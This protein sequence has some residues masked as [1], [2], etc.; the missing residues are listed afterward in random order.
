MILDG[1]SPL[2]NHLWQS[3]LCVL[4]VWLLTLAMKRNRAAVRYWLWLAA[5]MKFLVPFS[6][7]VSAGSQFGWHADA[8]V[9]QPQLVHAMDEIARP[10]SVAAPPPFSPE[11]PPSTSPVVAILLGLWLCG[12]AIDVRSWVRGWRRARAALRSGT[13]LR[14]DLP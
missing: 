5:S 2:A 7:L 4:A 12:F 1:L 10:F 8:A 6:V 11:V 13:P 14:L 9:S 3:T